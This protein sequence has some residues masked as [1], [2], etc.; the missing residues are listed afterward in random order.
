VLGDS[1]PE[2]FVAL[3]TTGCC[4]RDRLKE[5]IEDASKRTPETAQLLHLLDGLNGYA[6][7]LGVRLLIYDLPY[8]Q[9]N[10]Q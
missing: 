7:Q 3:V 8:G 6:R 10:Q 2:L 5:A 4:D 9:Q 1:N